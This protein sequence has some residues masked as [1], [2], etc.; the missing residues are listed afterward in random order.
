[1][2]KLFTQPIKIQGYILLL[3][4]PFSLPGFAIQ[5]ISVNGTRVSVSARS[6][7]PAARCPACHQISNRLHSYYLRSPADLPLSGLGVRLE[8][9]VR[10]FRCQNQ[11]CTQQTTARALSRDALSSCPTDTTA[12]RYLNSFCAGAEWKSRSTSAR[13]ERDVCHCR[14]ARP[15]SERSRISTHRGPRSLRGG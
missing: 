14:Y 1:M 13:P 7:S 5:E 3:M 2:K 6:T 15:A 8:L 4:F 11:Q 12:D 10:R 9:R